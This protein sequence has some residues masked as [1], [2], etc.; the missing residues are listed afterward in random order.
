MHYNNFRGQ[1]HSK[2]ALIPLK[3]VLGLPGYGITWIFSLARYLPTNRWLQE[4]LC[5][6]MPKGLTS[7]RW[8]GLCE[9]GNK[10]Y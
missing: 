3:V 1:N 8:L 9:G 2:Q 6:L 10:E 4:S 7:T 5:M